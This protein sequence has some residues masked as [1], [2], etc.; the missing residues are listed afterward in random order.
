[1]TDTTSIS[2]GR[3]SASRPNAYNPLVSGTFPVGTPVAQSISSAGVVAPGR[4]NSSATA[5]VTGIAVVPGVD[6]D[7]A[8]VQ[9]A[10]PVTLTEAEWDAITGE[11]GGL[12]LGPYYLDDGAA[13]K[14]TTTPPSFDGTFVVQVGIATSATDLMVQLGGIVQ[15]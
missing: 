11:T 10:G 1:M 5:F 15:N 4:A 3:Q 14:L 8:L 13:G 12:T 7:R 6:G 9:F 2:G